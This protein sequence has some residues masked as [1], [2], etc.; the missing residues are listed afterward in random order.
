MNQRMIISNIRMLENDWF[1]VKAAASDLGMSINQ[2]INF[3]VEKCTLNRALAKKPQKIKLKHDSIWDF[4]E[5]A[6]KIKAKPMGLSKEDEEIY[7]I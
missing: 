2:Y 6:K 7:S 5:L 4:P 1:A 3:V